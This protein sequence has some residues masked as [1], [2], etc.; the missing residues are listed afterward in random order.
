MDIEN[1]FYFIATGIENENSLN[2]VL[3]G[4]D[5]HGGLSSSVQRLIPKCNRRIDKTGSFPL[6]QRLSVIGTRHFGNRIAIDG[7]NYLEFPCVITSDSGIR[8]K[9]SGGCIVTANQKDFN[10][11]DGFDSPIPIIGE[12][13]IGVLSEHDNDFRLDVFSKNDVVIRRELVGY[14][15]DWS[16]GLGKENSL[17]FHFLLKNT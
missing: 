7:S 2:N 1:H 8:W 14:C 17:I 5:L 3:V 16:E 11:K 13:W 9:Y 4:V 15:P 12:D 6:S 10:I